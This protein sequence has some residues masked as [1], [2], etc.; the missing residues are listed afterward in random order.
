MNFDEHDKPYQLALNNNKLLS[1]GNN[2][3]IILILDSFEYM[4]FEE[5]QKKNLELINQTLS[6][7]ALFSNISGSGTDTRDSLP[8]ILTSKFRKPGENFSE[9]INRIWVERNPL[10]NYVLKNSQK[11]R[12]YTHDWIIS[13][14]S[15]A[16]IENIEPFKNY[17]LSE[18]I[19]ISYLLLNI[20][21]FK[22]APYYVRQWF[23]LTKD[24]FEYIGTNS[25]TKFTGSNFAFKTALE[26]FSLKKENTRGVLTIIHLD[27]M[28]KPYNLNSEGELLKAGELSNSIQ[29]AEGLMNLLRLYFLKLK[30]QKLFDQSEILI[31]SDHGKHG[32]LHSKPL[33][34]YK[35]ANQHNQLRSISIA[36]SHEHIMEDF[37]TNSML[38][39]NKNRVVMS[40]PNELYLIPDNVDDYTKWVAVDATRKI[41]PIQFLKG[42][43]QKED[44]G[45]RWLSQNGQ[46]LLNSRTKAIEF[47]VLM[48]FAGA[49]DCKSLTLKTERNS[50]TFNIKDTPTNIYFQ[51][52]NGVN[53]ITF[54]PNCRAISPLEIGY[55]SDERKLSFGISDIKITTGGDGNS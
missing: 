41:P 28:H 36:K 18:K 32:D 43:F 55:S 30:D 39:P 20:S 22:S 10:T 26:R 7:F 5:L 42:F 19:N 45:G 54:Q 17:L 48:T 31:M 25:E 11:I 13:P 52:P 21:F 1:V 4:T 15:T 29:H 9:Y 37:L 47:K 8:V 12:L 6:G 3:R 38:V 49:T 35:A 34:L 2:H 16:Y 14:N 23:H 24:P 27:G 40:S 51:I 50:S 46:V 44:W 33:L 53:K